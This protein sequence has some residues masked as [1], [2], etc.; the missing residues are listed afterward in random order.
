MTQEYHNVANSIYGPDYKPKNVLLTPFDDIKLKTEDELEFVTAFFGHLRNGKLFGIYLIMC[1]FVTIVALLGYVVLT[2]AFSR[3]RIKEIATR[4]LLGTSRRGIIVRCFCEA[5]TLLLV[6]LAFAVVLVLAFKEPVG[7]ILGK[8]I[9]PLSELNEYLV[10]LGIIILM[11][12]IASS[13]PSI[14]LSSYSPVNIIK[15]E[16]RYKDKILYGKIF[17]AIAGF[18]QSSYELSY[19][20]K[21]LRI[22]TL[23]LIALLGIS[24]FLLGMGFTLLLM[25]LLGPGPVLWARFHLGCVQPSPLPGFSIPT[26]AKHTAQE[27]E[28]GRQERLTWG[29]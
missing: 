19:A 6:S 24:G 11:V 14:I 7:Q 25:L 17:V 26:C 28:G 20:F 13:V 1:I 12:S 8:E 5:L 18:S 4:Q 23:L 22:L 29:R 3:F 10:L 15:G 16:A 21:F 27:W 9:H 2:I